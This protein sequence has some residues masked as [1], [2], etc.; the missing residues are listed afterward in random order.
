MPALDGILM[1]L[2]KDGKLKLTGFDLEVGIETYLTVEAVTPGKLIVNAKLFGDILRNLD[3]GTIYL[4]ADEKLNL[5][6]SCGVIKF[7][8]PCL[9]FDMY[10][11]MPI[12]EKS[13]VFKL[14]QNILHSMIR[15]TIFS[16]S[17]NDSRPALK[18][19]LFDII[20]N[21]IYIISSD[22]FKMAIRKETFD[23]TLGSNI[24]FIVPGKAL[25]ELVKIMNDNDD[26]IYI[27]LASHHIT[28]EFN[29]IKIISR[30][31]EGEFI[32]YKSI[33]PKA[34]KTTATIKLNEIQ[35]AVERAS[36]LISE[37]VKSPVRCSLEFDSIVI[38][39]KTSDGHSL[40]DE[41]RAEIKGDN[42]EI[43]FN[44]KYLLDIFNACE[45][46]DVC[47]MLNSPVTSMCV[48]PI[49]SEKFLFLISPMRL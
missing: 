17:A 4:E 3:N 44:N 21:E 42:L 15:Q 12:I 28:F 41:I 43:G 45:C 27:G 33:I 38:S 29:N 20:D 16:V 10:P 24:S 11:D 2:F 40:T 9:P 46:E 34:F 30:L 7:V 37:K 47:L 19:M 32:N 48:S 36:I 35:K 25:A 18:G 49:N 39:C 23:N 6:I 1:E 14:K 5:N 13:N 22:T 31:I 26:E 8:I